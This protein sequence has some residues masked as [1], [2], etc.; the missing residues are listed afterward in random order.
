MHIQFSSH[1]LP[2]SI[3]SNHRAQLYLKQAA[4]SWNYTLFKVIY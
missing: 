3:T 2:E 1:Q 4:P